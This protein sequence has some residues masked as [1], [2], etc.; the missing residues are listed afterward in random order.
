MN[1][2]IN[3]ATLTVVASNLAKNN[4]HVSIPKIALWNQPS[5]L[6]V[7]ELIKYYAQFMKKLTATLPPVNKK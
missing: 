5:A 2:H 4:H 6:S 1:T 7:K 3:V